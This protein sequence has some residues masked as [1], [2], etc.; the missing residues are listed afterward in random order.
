[1]TTIEDDVNSNNKVVSATTDYSKNIFF[2]DGCSGFMSEFAEYNTKVDYE[3]LFNNIPADVKKDIDDLADYYLQFFEIAEISNYDCDYN[4]FL[5]SI[6]KISGLEVDINIYTTSYKKIGLHV[7]LKKN[8]PINS[9]NEILQHIF[10]L[11]A[12]FNKP[13]KFK[14]YIF[15]MISNSTRY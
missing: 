2:I 6:P 5:D 9:E 7:S 12:P 1:M 13:I 15:N 3:E 4:L 10:F 8:D 11:N 14:N